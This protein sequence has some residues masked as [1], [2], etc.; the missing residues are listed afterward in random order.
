MANH[1]L[2]GGP[3][4]AHGNSSVTEGQQ[5]V[6][7]SLAPSR[8]RKVNMIPQQPI[9]GPREE[10]WLALLQDVQT[11]LANSPR[12][13]EGSSLPPGDPSYLAWASVFVDK[14][15]DG[16]L[17]LRESGRVPASK[18]LVRPALE[19]TLSAMAVLKEPGFLFRK[20]Y[21]ELEEEKKMLRNNP[22][23]IADADRVLHDMETAAKI[24][25][26]GSP[27]ERKK[28]D[29]AYTAKVAGQSVTYESTYRT[30]CKFTHGTMQAVQGH[31]DEATDS[32]DT[33]VVVWCV[34]MLLNQ[35]RQHTSA[36]VPDLE[37]FKK[38]LEA[39]DPS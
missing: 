24:A 9:H 34:L 36:G 28:V 29:M 33:D 6:S 4:T 18:L 2:N 20:L 37:P 38:R 15:A 23:A 27:L 3:A 13:L 17:W 19:A 30:Y 14:A 21:T 32:L 25:R 35:L 8:R 10:Q 22:A 16:Y 26:P 12:S 7:S 39:L 11:A 1:A 5:S 31:L